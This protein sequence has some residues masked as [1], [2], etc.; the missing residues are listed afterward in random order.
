RFTYIM[1]IY[2]SL[3][4]FSFVINFR[5]ADCASPG[6]RSP[7]LG[8]QAVVDRRGRS[9][10]ELLTTFPAESSV[11]HFEVAA[12]STLDLHHFFRRPGIDSR[13]A[14]CP[15][16]GVVSLLLVCVDS[17]GRHSLPVP[18]VTSASAHCGG[19]ECA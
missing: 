1:L 8:T 6:N 11:F 2:Q 5:R 7:S 19:H 4:M 9:G 12:I 17:V 16:G 3:P 14:S 10:L 18:H 13:H 15:A